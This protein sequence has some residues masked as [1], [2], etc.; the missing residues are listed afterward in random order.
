MAEQFSWVPLTYCSQPGCPFPVK[1]LA[2]LTRVFP[3][4]IHFWVLDK[5]PLSGP[6]RDPPFL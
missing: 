4:T 3:Q 5:S 1:S 6:E 2:L